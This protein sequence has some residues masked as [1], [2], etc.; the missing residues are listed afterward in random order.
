MSDHTQAKDESSRDE[1]SHQM[2][3]DCSTNQEGTPPSCC[4]P[5]CNRGE[6]SSLEAGKTE[7]LLLMKAFACYDPKRTIKNT[8]DHKNLTLD[9]VNERGAHVVQY[10]GGIVGNLK[11]TNVDAARGVQY[12]GIIDDHNTTNAPCPEDSPGNSL[13]CAQK[14]FLKHPEK[15]HDITT[16]HHIELRSGS[17]ALLDC[18]DRVIGGISISQHLSL[19]HI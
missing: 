9:I 4:V 2:C 7:A 19:I 18:K 12:L 16:T 13:Q 17:L 11:S 6:A 14:F 1:H 15:W 3:Q 5:T 8:L 10:S